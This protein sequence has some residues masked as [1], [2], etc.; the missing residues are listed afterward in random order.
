MFETIVETEDIS[1]IRVLITALKAHGFHPLDASDGGL[2]G[3]PGIRRL[4]GLIAIQVPA[5]EAGDAR[6]L[7]NSLLIDMRSRR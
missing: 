2:P 1:E 3:L 4:D 6:L 7:A 5:S